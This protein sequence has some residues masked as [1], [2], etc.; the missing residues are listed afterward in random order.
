MTEQ[1]A[2]QLK[3]GDRVMWRKEPDN[4]GVIVS[5]D[6]SVEVTVWWFYGR[7]ACRLPYGDDEWSCIDRLPAA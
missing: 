1:E 2:R 3:V 4:Y 7:Y 6:Q 5:L